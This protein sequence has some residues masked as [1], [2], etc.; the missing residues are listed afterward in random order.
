[1]SFELPE[2]ETTMVPEVRL[3]KAKVRG[4]VYDEDGY[5]THHEVQEM[6][7]AVHTLQ[8]AGKGFVCEFDD[9]TVDVV[10]YENVRFVANEED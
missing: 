10:P 2:Y 7:C 6:L 8:V 1:M 4:P 5:V 9:G 3:A